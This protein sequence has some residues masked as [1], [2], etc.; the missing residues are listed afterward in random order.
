MLATVTL[1]VHAHS[2]NDLGPIIMY[3]IGDDQFTALMEV[4]KASFGPH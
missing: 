4:N 2:R 3:I 1:F